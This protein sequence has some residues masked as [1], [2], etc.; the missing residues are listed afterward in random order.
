[1]NLYRTQRELEAGGSESRMLEAEGLRY[2][3]TSPRACVEREP[4]LASIEGKLAGGIF[5][6][7][8]R[9]GDAYAF[10]H[11]VVGAIAADG[12]RLLFGTEVSDWSRSGTQVRAAQTSAGPI[13][14]DGFVIAA[15]SYSRALAGRLGIDVPVLPAKGYSLSFRKEQLPAM[16]RIPVLDSSLH[17]AIT[18]IDGVLRVAGTA[19]FAG[20]DARIPSARIRNLQ[21]LL[22]QVY[23]QLA[24]RD[25]RIEGVAWT[26]FRPIS[27]DGVPLI[28]ATKIGNVFLNTGHGPLG[29]TLA[30]GSGELLAQC[31]TGEQS[32][33]D[34]TDYRPR[35]A[36]S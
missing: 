16:P 23:P 10:C 22:A 19:E 31:V 7:D 18:P 1:M 36:S 21:S 29:W 4:L 24:P 35:S 32:T 25:A 20:F 34:P 13:E 8:D 28:G 33:L 9:S 15:G 5:F 26:G 2:T 14:A 12:G 3:L 27:Y 30:A 17:A 11:A 6:P